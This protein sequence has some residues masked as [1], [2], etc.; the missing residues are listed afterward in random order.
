M[1]KRIR[2]ILPWMIGL[3]WCGIMVVLAGIAVAQAILEG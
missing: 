2:K 1:T 3:G